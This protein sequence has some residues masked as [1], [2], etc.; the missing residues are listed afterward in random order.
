MDWAGLR[1]RLGGAGL[2]WVGTEVECEALRGHWEGLRG[3]VRAED[4]TGKS[5]VGLGEVWDVL[6]GAQ[7]WS[8]KHWVV[9]GFTRRGWSHTGSALGCT[10]RDWGGAQDH[11]GRTVGCTGKYWDAL[12]STGLYWEGVLGHTGLY[13]SILGCTGRQ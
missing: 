11:I 9:L 1:T 5:W 4:E 10:G 12:G 6:R 2:A 7:D 3:T 8:R 13:G